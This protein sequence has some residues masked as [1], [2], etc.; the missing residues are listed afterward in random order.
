MPK[1]TLAST[2][3]VDGRIVPSSR[4]NL[5][6][7][8]LKAAMSSKLSQQLLEKHIVNIDG[9]KM[10]VLQTRHPVLNSVVIPTKTRNKQ[11]KVSLPVKEKNAGSIMLDR[12]NKNLRWILPSVYAAPIGTHATPIFTVQKAGTG[13]SG[14][15]IYNAVLQVPVKNVVDDETQAKTKEMLAQSPSLRFNNVEVEIGNATLTLP[16][17][18]T[19][20]SPKKM[21]IPGRFSEDK[22][23]VDFHLKGDSVGLAYML[24]TTGEEAI[25]SINSAYKCFTKSQRKV[26]KSISNAVL[27]P[28]LIQLSANQNLISQFKLAKPLVNLNPTIVSDFKPKSTT[29]S[30]RISGN[31][32]PA[33]TRNLRQKSLKSRPSQRLARIVAQPV[34]SP[35]SEMQVNKHILTS[36]IKNGNFGRQLTLAT[37]QA[38]QAQQKTETVYEKGKFLIETKRPIN[39]SAKTDPRHFVIKDPKSGKQVVF[40]DN[41]PWGSLNI[42]KTIQ[43][44]SHSDLSLS[45]KMAKKIKV[46]ES[47]IEPGRFIVIPQ[48]YVISREPFSGK[49]LFTATQLTHPEDPELNDI[50]F[51]VG[52]EPELTEKER[53]LISESLQKYLTHKTPIGQSIPEVYYDFPTSLGVGLRLQ[54]SDSQSEAQHPVIDGDVIFIPVTANN[55]TS[56]SLMFESLSNRSRGLKATIEFD[57][58]D[59]EIGVISLIINLCRTTGPSVN[60]SRETVGGNNKIIAQELAGR[61]HLIKAVLTQKDSGSVSEIALSPPVNLKPGN[62]VTLADPYDQATDIAL[63]VDEHPPVK[64]HIDPERYDVGD[65]VQ[66]LIVTTSLEPEAKFNI[67]GNDH[68]LRDFSF[69]IRSKHISANSYEITSDKETGIFNII[70]LSWDMPLHLY[71]NPDNRKCECR[72]TANFTD[73][74]TLQT[75]WLN[76]DYGINPDFTIRRDHFNP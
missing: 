46:Y 31:S 8:S 2:K 10:Q 40:G 13:V 12:H 15:V 11:E 43:K 57:L 47:L 23:Y 67:N 6:P 65:T 62:S 33:A 22:S 75:D 44:L 64:V 27:S 7:G 35:I 38:L 5:A 24:L 56:A 70:P 3:I 60:I 63:S 74:H 45:H 37:H 28:Q 25:I 69:E 18:L 29:L 21:D 17:V 32:R 26:P 36:A 42:G 9:G 34:T 14:D 48:T 39:L 30:K 52:L 20:G 59:D 54:W 41:P 68:Y 76:H 19:D 1:E 73:G 61:T 16:Y 71:L 58:P 53:F 66:M 4:F 49:T 50:S 51:D 55:L 72:I